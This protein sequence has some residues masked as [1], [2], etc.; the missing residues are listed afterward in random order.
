MLLKI[1]SSSSGNMYFF[2]GKMFDEIFEQ[3]NDLSLDEAFSLNIDFFTSSSDFFIEDTSFFDFDFIDENYDV[4]TDLEHNLLV[5]IDSLTAGNITSLLSKIYEFDYDE[6]LSSDINDMMQNVHDSVFSSSFL[7][8]NP[9]SQFFFKKDYDLAEFQN[10]LDDYFG[11]DIDSLSNYLNEDVAEFFNDYQL[12]D[13]DSFF[14]SV[15]PFYAEQNALIDSTMEHINDFNETIN[16]VITDNFLPSDAWH[17]QEAPNSCAV[18]VQTDIL[19]D[20]GIKVSEFDMRSL[21]EELGIYTH[22][23]G[24]PLSFVGDLLEKHGIPLDPQRYDFSIADI[25]EAK[26]KGEKIILGLDAS[27]I[28]NLPDVAD[29]PLESYS[30]GLFNIA[31]AGHAVEFKGIMEDIYGNIKVIL[32]DPGIPNGQNFTVDLE[33]FL[34]AWKDFSNFAVITKVN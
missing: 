21:A 22:E 32:D 29:H 19:N 5:N 4:M 27:E 8:D 16:N 11:A 20:F 15:D 6:I 18:A 9:M 2:R 14:E 24:T 26:E 25:I 17:F 23:G 28:W 13:F 3:V 30:G 1:I 34:D 33:D 10:L 12:I 7:D 31:S